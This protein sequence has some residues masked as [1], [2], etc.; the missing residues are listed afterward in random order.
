VKRGFLIAACL[1]LA[2]CHLHPAPTDLLEDMPA[3]ASLQARALEAVD[4][5]RIDF[6]A[7][8]CQPIYD[9]ASPLFRLQTSEDWLHDCHR[10]RQELGSWRRF[11][12]SST[13]RYGKPQLFVF[14]VGSAE[15]ERQATEVGINMVLVG[16][17]AYLRSFSVRDGDQHWTDLPPPPRSNP[18]QWA[19]PPP[20]KSPEN[21]VAL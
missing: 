10:L 13:Q 5:F 17:K 19:D 9:Q 16:D 21:G 20:V 12:M 7:S 3:D 2:A 15:F 1:L 18:R 14:V 11:R 8:A 4:N 6:N